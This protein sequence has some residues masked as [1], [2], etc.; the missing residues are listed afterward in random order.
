MA[1]TREE[2]YSKEQVLK[3]LN[4]S[5]YVTYAK[6]FNMFDLNLTNQENVVA[7]VEMGKARIVVNRN[8]DLGSISTII[9]HEI[10]HEYF[11]HAIREEAWSKEKNKKLDRQAVNYAADFDIANKGYTDSDKE[12]VRNLTINNK[13]MRGLI[14]E[15]DRP[16]LLDKTF[17]EM[18]DILSEE[19]ESMKDI[20][21][22]M[23]NVNA[24]PDEEMQKAEDLERQANA[25]TDDAGDFV[26]QDENDSDDSQ[27]GSGSSGDGEDEEDTNDSDGKSGKSKGSDKSDKQS[28]SSSGD[29]QDSSDEE[30]TADKVAKEAAKAK[31]EIDELNDEE[32]PLRTKEEQDRLNKIAARIEKLKDAMHNIESGDSM[33]KEVTINKIRERAAKRASDMDK[34][35]D[36]QLQKF[37]MSFSKFI[38]NSIGLDRGTTWKKFNKTYSDT[39]IIRPGISRSVSTK[40]PVVNVYFDRSGSWDAEKSKKGFQVVSAFNRYVKQGQLQINLYYFAG[41]VYSSEQAAQN[42]GST[43]GQPILDHIAQTKPDNV[44]IMTDDDIYDCTTDCVVKG[45]VWLVFVNHQI[46]KNLIEHIKGL[47]LTEVYDISTK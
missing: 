7:Y 45:A 38:K 6:L 37:N 19:S 17:E 15:D 41:K 42:D 33:Q 12:V 5:G 30:E 20:A 2:Y 31:K 44:I 29:S 47:K 39:G 1:M 11:D 21:Q 36:K 34:Y 22:K 35:T 26:D 25:Y 14:T 4:E 16:D 46:S 43:R 28:S 40:V 18:L 27:D 13:L 24:D 23:A 32:T 8:I 3:V 9:R 10:L